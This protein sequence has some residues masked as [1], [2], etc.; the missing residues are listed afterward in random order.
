MYD[1]PA[2]KRV[3]YNVETLCMSY[4]YN[5]WQSS[6]DCLTLWSAWLSSWI[7]SKKWSDSRSKTS[8]RGRLGRPMIWWGS[9]AYTPSTLRTTLGREQQRLNESS[10]GRARQ[11]GLHFRKNAAD[12][13]KKDQVLSGPKQKNGRFK[14][15]KV[16][17]CTSRIVN[18]W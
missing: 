9:G 10:R 6:L 14:L 18:V 5:I 16:T 8:F 4:V 15:L 2:L 11:G 12:R 13:Q 7:A 3:T 17:I 1:T